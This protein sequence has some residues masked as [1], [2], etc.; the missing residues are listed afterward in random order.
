MTFQKKNKTQTLQPLLIALIS[1]K[2]VLRVKITR[3]K[4]IALMLKK[5]QEYL[6]NR[7]SPTRIIKC[8]VNWRHFPKFKPNLIFIRFFLR[9][10]LCNQDNNGDQDGFGFIS[11][12]EKKPDTRTE[13]RLYLSGMIRVNPTI[14]GRVCQ[15]CS[16]KRK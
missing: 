9:I 3:K 11:V 1:E 6:K 8:G 14:T 10:R 15:L 13:G 4:K 7:K 16:S 2:L 12:T 5:S